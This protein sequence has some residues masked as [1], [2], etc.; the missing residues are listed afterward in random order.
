MNVNYLGNL[1]SRSQTETTSD[2]QKVCQAT[3]G[4]THF[5]YHLPEFQGNSKYCHLKT[6]DSGRR[7]WQLINSGPKFC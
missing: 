3:E 4:C 2:C 7:A 5:S 6:S 1:L